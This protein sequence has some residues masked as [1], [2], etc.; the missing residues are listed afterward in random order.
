MMEP[1]LVGEIVVTAEYV[2]IKIEQDTTTF[3]AKAFKNKA[4]AG[5]VNL[6]YNTVKY[7]R[8]YVS[9]LGNTVKTDRIQST[10]TEKRLNLNGRVTPRLFDCVS[11]NVSWGV[12]TIHDRFS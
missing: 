5:G 6:S 9:Y 4:G 11:F 2:P 10:S 7:N 12:S 1:A 3:N 8:Y